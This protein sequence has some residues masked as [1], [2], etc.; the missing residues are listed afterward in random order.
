MG[1]RIK[2]SYI[3][4]LAITAGL[5]AWMAAGDVVIGGQGDGANATPP[6][7]ERQD[8][9]TDL[10]KVR[11]KQIEAGI[12]KPV[13]EIRGRTEADIRMT[14][15]AETTGLL[16]ER[17]VSRGDHVKKGDLVCRLDPR[18]RNAE[19][20][21]AKAALARAELD[22]EAQSTLSDK[23]FASK[24]R[25]SAER[26]NL[27]AARANLAAAELEL[28]RTE[29]YAPANGVVLD[30]IADV[31]E[32]LEAGNPCISL[33]DANPMMLIGQVSE[34]D[35]A[36]LKIGDKAKAE[37]ITGQSTIGTI[38]HIASAADA[39]TRTFRVEIHI[40][41]AD[42]SIKD[43]VTAVAFV[44]L[45]DVKGHLISPALLTLSDNGR[46]GIR[47]VKDGMVK[48]YPVKILGDTGDGVWIAGLPDT[49]TLITV[50]QDY[51]V[52]GQA[53]EAVAEQDVTEQNGAQS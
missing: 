37:L 15:R 19:V 45:P 11:V 8:G 51:V 21:R 22:Y 17:F 28:K 49:L 13:L 25:V 14:V 26:A 6:P 32:L 2:G 33:M 34:R 12:R 40:D 1:F 18:T 3:I 23:G 53:V 7:A 47:T 41:N 30:P 44:Q 48:F 35:V 50:G 38:R 20:A 5:G 46:V 10:F 31:G 16:M 29:V 39:Q 36:Q 52:D 4:A 9:K 42:L 43:G 24:T 27:D